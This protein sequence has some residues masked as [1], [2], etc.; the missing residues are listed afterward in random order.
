MF[1]EIYLYFTYIVSKKETRQIGWNRVNILNCANTGEHWHRSFPILLATKSSSPPP[2][3]CLDQTPRGGHRKPREAAQCQRLHYPSSE[4][5]WSLFSWKEKPGCRGACSG[6]WTSSARQTSGQTR[7]PSWQWCLLNAQNIFHLQVCLVNAL[8]LYDQAGDVER[9]D[10]KLDFFNFRVSGFYLATAPMAKSSA[11]IQLF[12]PTKIYLYL[13]SCENN[14]T[15]PLLLTI[16]SVP[17]VL[18]RWSRPP[19]SW[20]P[21]ALPGDIGL[22]R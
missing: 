6:H 3:E 1:L 12:T 16:W 17:S 22:W 8:V 9:P 13:T 5:H 11:Q 15:K 7:P 2:P 20:S 18:R 4:D 21:L 14:L 10:K 19:C